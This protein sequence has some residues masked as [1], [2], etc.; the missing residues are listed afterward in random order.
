M[1]AIID[2]DAGNIRSVEKALQY[3]GQEVTITR[4]GEEIL[5]ADKVILPGV[6]SFGDAMEKIRQYDLEDVIRRVAEQKTPF[7]GICLGLQLLFEQ[8]EESPGARGVGLLKGQILRIPEGEGRKIP[9]MG[10]NSLS[11][12]N[13]GRLFRGIPD[14]AYVYFV[15]SYYLKAADEKIVKASAEYGI[16]IHASVERDNIF[17]CQFHPEKSGDTGLQ[18]LKNFIEI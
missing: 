14:G 17:A 9:H 15:H 6:G 2:Y 18:I 12:R 16:S 10:W 11:L 1:I 3:L 5:A 8:S 4:Q 7:L 13:E